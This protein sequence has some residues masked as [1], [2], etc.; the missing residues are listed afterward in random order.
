MER[1]RGFPFVSTIETARAWKVEA[2]LELVGRL[3]G[4]GVSE[5]DRAWTAALAPWGTTRVTAASPERTKRESTSRDRHL[6]KIILTFPPSVR[7]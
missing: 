4:S 1:I 3:E 7:I 6:R 5:I 2:P